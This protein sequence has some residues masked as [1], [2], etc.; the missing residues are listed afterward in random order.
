MPNGSAQAEIARGAVVSRKQAVFLDRVLK[1][2]EV[3]FYDPQRMV[4]SIIDTQTA[5]SANSHHIVTINY[6]LRNN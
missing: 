3:E 6:R 1:E 5:L 4:P 2:C